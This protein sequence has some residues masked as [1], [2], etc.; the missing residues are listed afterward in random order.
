[1]T[2]LAVD[3]SGTDTTGSLYVTWADYASAMRTSCCP[4]A[5]TPAQA[6]R[7]PSA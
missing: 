6:G 5:T 7:A 3:M 1:M 4:T 2:A